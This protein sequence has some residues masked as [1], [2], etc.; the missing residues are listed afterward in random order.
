MTAPISISAKTLRMMLAAVLPHGGVDDTLP[1]LNAVRLEVRGG[2]LYLIATDRYSIGV[3]RQPVP[4]ATIAP[5]PDQDGLLGLADAQNLYERLEGRDV[6]PATIVIT[7]G[8]IAVDYGDAVDSWTQV[9]LMGSTW[10]D[11]RKVL[12]EVLA[13][14]PGSLDNRFGIDMR[15]LARFSIDPG[16][17]GAWED[18]EGYVK[19][20]W[21]AE[22]ARVRIV[23]PKAP[24]V[25]VARGNWFLGAAMPA[26]LDRSDTATA[27]SWD[28]WAAVCRPADG[29][30]AA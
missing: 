24:T 18:D 16:R 15:L 8:E 4:G 21:D 20:E 27:P 19:P 7:D 9:R 6:G 13:A 12:R 22:A 29:E 17:Y 11:W 26:R 3:A 28:D 23:R 5:V 1:T 2:V 30:V 14:E 10:P 25:L